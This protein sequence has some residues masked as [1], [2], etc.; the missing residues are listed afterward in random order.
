MKC[1]HRRRRAHAPALVLLA[2][3]LI[4]G[5]SPSLAAQPKKPVWLE[6]VTGVPL[7]KTRKVAHPFDAVFGKDG[8]L[9]LLWISG[10]DGRGRNLHD[11]IR[12]RQTR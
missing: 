10:A 1:P 7:P 5:A 2:V 3:G 12:P 6:F 11:A 9:H 8:A 4:T